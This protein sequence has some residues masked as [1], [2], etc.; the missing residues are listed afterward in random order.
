[1]RRKYQVL[2]VAP[3]AMLLPA[4]V[5]VASAG[6]FEANLRPVPHRA[7][8][9]GGS[10]VT[11]KASLRLEGRNL[12]VDLT[13]RG[14]TPSQPHAMHIHGVLQAHNECPTIAADVNTGDPIDPATFVQGTPDGLISLGE[15]APFYG[16][17][18]VSLTKTGDTSPSSGL[19]L[20]RFVVADDSG[21]IE[22][23]RSITI[24]KDVAKDLSNLHIVVHGT[25]LPSD[26]D[27]SS[28]SSLFEATLPVACGE[29]SQD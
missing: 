24:P 10:N 27:H 1:M 25:D 20:E 16:P 19:S 11:G 4:G 29:I 14:L 2:M 7:V 13:A 6:H 18:D 12:R 26:A 28:L 15:G 22:Y 9:D 8:A 17:V 21:R 5:A 3:V 23:H